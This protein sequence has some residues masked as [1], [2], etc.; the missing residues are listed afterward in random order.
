MQGELQVQVAKLIK[1]VSAPDIVTE[2]P[3]LYG[4][5]Y[6]LYL[7]ICHSYPIIQFNPT[8]HAL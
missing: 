4:H 7:A 8:L 5:K 1:T 6:K 3:I 2:I